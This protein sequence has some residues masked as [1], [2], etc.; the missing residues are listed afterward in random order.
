MSPLGHGESRQFSEPRISPF[1][2]ER[3]VRYKSERGPP[4]RHCR[5]RRSA[6][7]ARRSLGFTSGVS[8]FPFSAEGWRVPSEQLSIRVTSARA[9]GNEIPWVSS[10]V[11]RRWWTPTWRWAILLV[12]VFAALLGAALRGWLLLHQPLTGDEAIV[13]LMADQIRHGHFYTFYWGQSYGGV[14][15]YLVALFSVVFGT[16]ALVVR[17]TATVL[18][19]ISALLVWR[20][21]RRLVPSQGG[22]LGLTAAAVFWV[23]PQAAVWNSTRELGFRGVTMA[24]G[25]ASILFALRVIDRRSLLDSAALGLFLGLGWWSSPESVYFGIPTLGLVASGLIR[26]RT[27]WPRRSLH[28]IVPIVTG[29]VLGALPWIWTNLHTGFA[30]LKVSSSP[31]Y[32][33]ASYFGRLSIFFHQTLPMMLGLRVP[34]SG[35]WVGGGAGR[36]LFGLAAVVIAAVCLGVAIAAWRAERFAN[37]AW[38]AVAVLIFPFVFAAFPATSYWE[39]GQY[40]A[41]IVPFIL[42]VMFGAV[43]LL[44]RARARRA[45]TGW[46]QLA[47]PVVL[48]AV[49]IFAAAIITVASFD[50]VW[51]RGHGKSFL[52]GWH[53]PNSV[54]E[55][56]ARGLERDG[57]KYAYSDYWT[58]Y[59]LDLLSN[60]RLAVSDVY[61]D[62]WVAL[63]YQVRSAPNQAWIFHA[64][65]R[66]AEA[67]AAFPSSAIGPFGY[68]EALFLAKLKALGISYRVVEAGVLDAVLPARSVTQEDVGIPPPYWH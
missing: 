13:G 38:C 10:S 27:E 45:A 53:D 14:E 7:R 59:D 41:Y 63:Y 28:W 19:A 20:I 40:G 34:I 66:V 26:N 9:V 5:F 3:D 22:W 35:T 4:R 62:R 29:F 43:G 49:A 2:P 15:P 1:E 51:L 55:Q 48:S 67:S 30:S 39:E 52:A 21:V 12:C 32:V 68:P 33:H 61:A 64:P 17:V 24:A 11:M 18:A 65:S 44:N 50:D 57:V 16:T 31:V 58:A 47:A 23:W 37:I 36:A 25:L 6:L 8:S 46:M 42:F 56:A 60:N 54:G